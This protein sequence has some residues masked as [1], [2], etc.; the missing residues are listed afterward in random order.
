MYRKMASNTEEIG[1][2]LKIV[3]EN[4]QKAV[5]ARPKVHIEYCEFEHS[6]R[7]VLAVQYFEP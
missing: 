1:K 3:L 2:S 6:F 4:I 5:T 7:F